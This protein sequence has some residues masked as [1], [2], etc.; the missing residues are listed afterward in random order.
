YD[1]AS[2]ALAGAHGQVD[3][4]FAKA[5]AA[6]HDTPLGSICCHPE[7]ESKSTTISATIFLPRQRQI[8]F[9]H[10]LP[11]QGHYDTYSV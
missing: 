5:L 2:Q 10:G 4:A 9:C 6:T 1:L 11:C 3:V 7:A 8:L